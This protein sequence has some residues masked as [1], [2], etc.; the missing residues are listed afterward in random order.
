M[1]TPPY[2]PYN[3]AL[4]HIKRHILQR[5]E[6]IHCRVGVLVKDPVERRLH[7]IDNGITEREIFFLRSAELVFFAEPTDADGRV[8][9]GPGYERS[10]DSIIVYDDDELKFH[11]PGSQCLSSDSGDSFDEL[12]HHYRRENANVDTLPE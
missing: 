3:L 11:I 9:C 5:P 4:L 8:V 10:C 6:L 12:C 1:T 7:G 2:D